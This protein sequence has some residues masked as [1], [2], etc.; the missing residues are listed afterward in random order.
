MPEGSGLFRDVKAV[1]LCRLYGRDLEGKGGWVWKLSSKVWSVLNFVIPLSIFSIVL[2]SSLLWLRDLV[3]E[4]IYRL[5]VMLSYEIPK[6]LAL[7]IWSVV[8]IPR[9]IIRS[10]WK[11]KIK[12][13][14]KNIFRRIFSRKV[15]I[16]PSRF[17]VS[18]PFSSLI[19]SI[20]SFSLLSL[21]FVYFTEFPCIMVHGILCRQGITN[22]ICKY[23]GKKW[24]W[25][26]S[27]SVVSLALIRLKI[28]Y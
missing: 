9:E 24:Q 20:L 19:S 17:Y 3:S 14:G 8:F 25:R 15:E 23:S 1:F 18:F 26:C 11:T 22:V 10:G 13:W 16:K 12:A 5:S 6:L 28:N 4:A 27:C 7:E 2:S 21:N